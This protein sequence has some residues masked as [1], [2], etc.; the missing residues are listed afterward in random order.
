MYVRLLLSPLFLLTSYL[1]NDAA[2]ATKHFQILFIIVKITLV[3]NLVI[4]DV[5]VLHLH[6]CASVNP[7]PAAAV[8]PPP[9]PARLNTPLSNRG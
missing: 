1:K 9:P 5:V 7:S 2:D 3:L 4:P 8:V 6:D